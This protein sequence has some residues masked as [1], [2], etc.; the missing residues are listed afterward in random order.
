MTKCGLESQLVAADIPGQLIAMQTC[1]SLTF[2]SLSS[3][4]HKYTDTQSTG[5]MAH[6]QVLLKTIAL[7]KLHKGHGGVSLGYSR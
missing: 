7:Q 5:C 6:S 2:A 3:N 1:Q 4:E